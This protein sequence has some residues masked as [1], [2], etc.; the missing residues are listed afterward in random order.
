MAVKR[1]IVISKE[2]NYDVGYL[3]RYLIKLFDDNI[4][5]SIFLENEFEIITSNYIKYELKTTEKNYLLELDKKE[6]LSNYL[7]FA[8]HPYS[9]YISLECAK[10]IKKIIWL[11]DPHYLAYYADRGEK[12]V[13]QFSEKFNP[14][15]LSDVDYLVTP[16]PIWFKNLNIQEYDEKIKDFFYFLDESIYDLTGN[17]EYNNRSSK[18]VLS[19]AIGPGYLSRYEFDKLRYKDEFSDLIYKI[20]HPGY[21]NNEH[22]TELKYYD[23]LTKFKA[24]FVGHYIFPLNFLLAKHIEVLMCGCLGFFEPNPLLKDQLGLIEFEHY[25][26]CYDENGLIK[27]EKF[28][29]DWMNSEEG[30]KIANQGKEY[31]RRKFGKEYIK[32]FI[33]FLKSV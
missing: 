22:M 26:S 29:I 15:F 23:E 17:L 7:I 27:D 24:A 33:N 19:G 28:Y 4:I 9:V 20:E 11:N 5:K 32:E 10:R 31:V 6:D 14:P 18:I 3:V 12:T 13:Q 2:N 21:N 1:L 30:K 8:I 25:V 16:S